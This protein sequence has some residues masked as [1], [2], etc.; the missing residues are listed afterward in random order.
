MA[1]NL[2]DIHAELLEQ[3]K[4]ITAVC[5]RHGIPYKLYCSQICNHYN[6][7][8]SNSLHKSPYNYCHNR[9]HNSRHS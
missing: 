6:N 7:H 3:L 9:S 1:L 5:E 4:D 2:Q 8:L